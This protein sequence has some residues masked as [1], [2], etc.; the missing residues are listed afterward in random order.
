MRMAVRPAIGVRAA[1][2]IER[3][4]DRDDAPAKPFHHSFDDVV[5]PDAQ[6]LA[7][8]LRLQMAVAEVPCDS[9]HRGGLGGDDFSERFRRGDDLDE[10]TVVQA[11]SIAAAQNCGLGEIEQER[12]ATHAA[13]R[14]AAAMTRVEVK[15]N[16]IN[17]LVM[18][19]TG[20]NGRGSH[21]PKPHQSSLR[22]E[23]EVNQEQSVGSWVTSL[24]SQ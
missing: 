20:D 21:D 16:D 7:N 22:A 13:H 14:H 8:E 6:L 11:K 10:A 17:G 5:T 24:R 15:H 23:G 9:H 12:R 4:L 19:A 2:G 18:P 1:L 3:C